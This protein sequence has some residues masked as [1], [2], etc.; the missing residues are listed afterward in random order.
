MPP[1]LVASAIPLARWALPAG[2]AGAALL[3]CCL[4]NRRARSAPADLATGAA[5][6]AL[7]PLGWLATGLAQGQPES[8]NYLALDRAAFTLP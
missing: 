8:I 4:L 5:L 6:G 3:A 1:T 7:V 2:I